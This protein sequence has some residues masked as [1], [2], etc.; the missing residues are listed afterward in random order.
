MEIEKLAQSYSGKRVLV[1]GH[2][3]FKGSWLV[4]VLQR[5][6]AVVKGYALAP[7]TDPSHHQLLAIPCE[8]ITAD[9]R[10][11]ERLTKEMQS[12][13]PDIVLHLAAQPLVR[14]SYAHP[15]ETY[16]TN[17]IGSLNLYEAVRATDS[18]RA[19]VSITTDKVYKNREWL[20]GYREHEELGGYDPYSSSKACVEIMTASYRNSYFNLNDYG[21]KH[22][23]LLAT[24]RA[25]N[26]V[27]GGD[28]SLDRLIPDIVKATA[29]GTAVFIRNP[30]AVRPWQ[31]VLEPII[32][33]LAVASKLMDGA[34]DIADAFNFGPDQDANVPVRTVTEISRKYWPGIGVTWNEQ[35]HDGQPHEANLLFLDN[36][37]AKKMLQWYPTWN[38]ETTIANTIAWY[39][40]Y[41]E[42][43]TILT[44]QQIDQYLID[45]ATAAQR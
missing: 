23:V 21:S 15:K 14:Y 17:V 40:A 1:T 41:Y 28:W 3:G 36:A 29:A 44:H 22:Q 18:V 39:K 27:G 26:V 11:G 25:G 9:I 20:W 4:A 13:K 42:S 16:E 34:V 6:G 32:G 7:N 24:V 43:K 5:M 8:S 37:K 2:T 19:V 10:D 35:T 30:D 45:L 38:I 31:H 12:F 33:Y